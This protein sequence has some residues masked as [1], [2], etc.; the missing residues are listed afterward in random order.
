M[1]PPYTLAPLQFRHG[2]CSAGLP[3]P[4]VC[5]VASP[6]RTRAAMILVTA[7]A[8]AGH[9]PHRKGLGGGLASQVTLLSRCMQLWHLHCLAV[10]SVPATAAATLLRHSE[11]WRLEPLQGRPWRS[12]EMPC[13]LRPPGRRP[14]DKLIQ[15]QSPC[16]QAPAW[17]LRPSATFSFLIGQGVAGCPSVQGLAGCAPNATE[18]SNLLPYASGSGAAN[19]SQT[20]SASGVRLQPKGRC[21]ELHGPLRHSGLSRSHYNLLTSVPCIRAYP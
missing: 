5:C 16:Q 3:K 2:H 10:A 8:A 1:D 6:T 12:K 14:S 7:G 17:R 9:S 20:P 15:H 4:Q 13:R 11:V 21:P 18:L 19:R